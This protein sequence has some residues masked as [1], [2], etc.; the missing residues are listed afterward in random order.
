MQTDVQNESIQY[1][2]EVLNVTTNSLSLPVG[3]RKPVP[4]LILFQVSQ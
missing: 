1:S 3:D 4:C 2:M